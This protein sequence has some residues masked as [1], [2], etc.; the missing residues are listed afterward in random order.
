MN[1]FTEQIER[2]EL[3]LKL[4]KKV[5]RTLKVFGAS[6]HKY[7]IGNVVSENKI[8][9]FEHKYNIQIPICYKT[10]LTKIG[11]GGD[12]Y[13]KSAAG[14]F[15]GIYPFGENIDE[16][17]DY[18]EEY[19]SKKVKIHPNMTDEFWEDLIRKIEDDNEMSDEEYDKEMG[20]LFAGILPIGS[21]G[22]TYLHGIILNGEHKGKVVNLD[23]SRQKPKFTHENNFLDWYERWLD[24]VNSGELLKSST[25]WYGYSK[26]KIPEISY[27]IKRESVL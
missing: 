21:Q 3:K 22:C 15:Y 17:I 27:R 16:L 7:K 5:D 13:Q 10:F 24:E 26:R 8:K 12:S 20:N 19:L 11:N 23:V 6:S 18:P 2:I 14:P 25:N 1:N 4:A 9:N